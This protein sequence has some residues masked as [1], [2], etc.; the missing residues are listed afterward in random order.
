[1]PLPKNTRFRYREL[2]EKKGKERRQRLA[3]APKTNKVIEAQT[4]IKNKNGWV[5][6]KG[7]STK[8]GTVRQI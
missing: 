5:T 2:P 8:R 7:S 1:M 3:F 4:Q 6:V